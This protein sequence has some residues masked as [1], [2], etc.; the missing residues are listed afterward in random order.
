M[1]T[2]IFLKFIFLHVCGNA[3]ICQ[4]IVATA[5]GQPAGV[6]FL[7]VHVGPEIRFRFPGSVAKCLF[8]LSHLTSSSFMFKSKAF[9]PHLQPLLL[10]AFCW[11]SCLSHVVSHLWGSTSEDEHMPLESPSSVT[12]WASHVDFSSKCVFFS[13]TVH[14]YRDFLFTCRSS[15]ATCN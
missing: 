5:K 6:S 10:F 11:L 3:C 2:F 15:F 4:S 7:I 8:L 14:L 13:L 12:S 1:H 9:F